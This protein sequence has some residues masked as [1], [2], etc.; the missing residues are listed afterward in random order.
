[1]WSCFSHGAAVYELAQGPSLHPVLRGQL[2]TLANDGRS[3]SHDNALSPAGSPILVFAGLSV[4]H[5][6]AEGNREGT[7]AMSGDQN[8][9]TVFSNCPGFEDFHGLFELAFH[10]CRIG[11]SDFN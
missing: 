10:A 7:V 2:L 11:G 3:L 6:I 5:S 1:M 8:S 9:L 4:G